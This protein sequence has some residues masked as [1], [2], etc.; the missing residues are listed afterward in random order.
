M[1]EILEKAKE[2]ENELVTNRRQIHSN[3]EIGLELE[4]TTEYVVKKL[5]EIGI[6][7]KV[8]SKS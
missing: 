4:K 8:I 2:L 3:P 5:K 1:N 7:P 6:E